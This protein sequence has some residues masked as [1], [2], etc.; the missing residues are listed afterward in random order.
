MEYVF[1]FQKLKE[2]SIKL[3]L[4]R[5]QKKMRQSLLKIIQ[6]NTTSIQ[7]WDRFIAERLDLDGL[8]EKLI[9]EVLFIVL[10]LLIKSLLTFSVLSL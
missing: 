9:N 5:K 6:L 4:A 2:P 7:I 1:H 8:D 10:E 3:E